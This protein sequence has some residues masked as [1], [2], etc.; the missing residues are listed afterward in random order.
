MDPVE[1]HEHRWLIRWMAG[2]DK[3]S[4]ATDPDPI[5]LISMPDTLEDANA[6]QLEALLPTPPSMPTRDELRGRLTAM[7]NASRNAGS[8]PA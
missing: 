4:R 6:E 8:M 3:E 7:Q 5:D 2:L 1:K